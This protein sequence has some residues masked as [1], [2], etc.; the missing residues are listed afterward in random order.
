MGLIGVGLV[1]QRTE[2]L[3]YIESC[4]Y[5]CSISHSKYRYGAGTITNS[6]IRKVAKK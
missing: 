3:Q 5:N 1:T 6:G 4:N 2:L